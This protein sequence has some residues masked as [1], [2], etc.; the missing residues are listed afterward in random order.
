VWTPLDI[1][2]VGLADIILNAVIRLA[3]IPVNHVFKSHSHSTPPVIPYLIRDPV[4]YFVILDSIGN[5]L[6][7]FVILDLIGDPLP[8]PVILDSIGDP[9][10]YSVIPYLIRDPVTYFSPQRHKVYE[11]SQR[12]NPE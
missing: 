10:P 11:V 1:K 4:P 6:P 8:Y 2:A 12:K 3:V 7:Y 5:P 9:L